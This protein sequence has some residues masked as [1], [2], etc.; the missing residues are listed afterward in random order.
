MH[1]AAACVVCVARVVH[2][3]LLLLL[4]LRVCVCVC[5]CVLCA[6]DI[7]STTDIRRVVILGEERFLE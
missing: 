6:T 7:E 4:L 1:A 2:R 3:C 5:V